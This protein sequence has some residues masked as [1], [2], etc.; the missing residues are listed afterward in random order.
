M[1]KFTKCYKT[2]EAILNIDID[3]VPG[4]DKFLELFFQI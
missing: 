2:C 4:T 3:I 1:S